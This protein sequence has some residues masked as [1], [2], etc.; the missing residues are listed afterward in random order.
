[1][2]RILPSLARSKSSE[3][4]RNLLV[5]RS[6]IPGLR[7]LLRKSGCTSTASVPEQLHF[8][9]RVP[10]SHYVAVYGGPVAVPARKYR[11][12]CMYF[13]NCH[14]HTL[15]VLRAC[16][17]RMIYYPMRRWMRLEHLLRNFRLTKLS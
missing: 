14:H 13:T 9:P 15:P 2:S 1:M 10:A 7:L 16:D 17:K 4:W 5:D 12:A 8:Y 11:K 3:I 6:A